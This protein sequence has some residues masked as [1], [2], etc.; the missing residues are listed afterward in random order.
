VTSFYAGSVV[1]DVPDAALPELAVED[2]AQALGLRTPPP[3]RTSAI[4]RW[5]G[6]IPRYGPGH[7]RRTAE[8]QKALAR[9]LPGL[10]LAGSWVCGVSVE[11][12]VEAGRRAAERIL[13]RP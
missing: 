11:L 9:E 8:L 2:L 12:V 6:V 10:E 7:A 3:V 1:A 13:L 5:K 4:I